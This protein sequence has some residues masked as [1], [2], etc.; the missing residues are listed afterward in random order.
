MWDTMVKA[1]PVLSDKAFRIVY[2]ALRSPA[3]PPIPTT[4]LGCNVSTAATFIVESW[5]LP[6]NYLYELRLSDGSLQQC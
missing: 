2:Y 5:F 6:Q 3:H 1:I 4:K